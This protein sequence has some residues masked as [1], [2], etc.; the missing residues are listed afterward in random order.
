[1]R[2]RGRRISSAVELSPPA[3]EPLQSRGSEVKTLAVVENA[4]CVLR[5]CGGQGHCS[6]GAEGLAAVRSVQQQG[7]GSTP[8]RRAVV[9]LWGGEREGANCF[10]CRAGES[11][12][13]LGCLP[14]GWGGDSPRLVERVRGLSRGLL[15]SGSA[16]RAGGETR[17]ERVTGLG[18]VRALGIL[19]LFGEGSRVRVAER[20]K[21]V[22]SRSGR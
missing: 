3:R 12:P 19:A 17:G 13:R 7:D 20:A 10:L 6:G 2:R 21:V 18:Q 15:A 14:L 8:P 9:S 1:M 22:M 11:A 4:V 5:S 16:G